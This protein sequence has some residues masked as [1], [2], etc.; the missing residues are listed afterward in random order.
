MHTHLAIIPNDITV[1]PRLSG[2]GMVNVALLSDSVRGNTCD[3]QGRTVNNIK[4]TPGHISL[5]MF[6]R[7]A[8]DLA[9]NLLLSLAPD[10]RA[11]VIAQFIR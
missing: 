10:E 3:A 8:A 11:A 7:Q 5:M 9:G 1:R 2:E 6:S 4:G